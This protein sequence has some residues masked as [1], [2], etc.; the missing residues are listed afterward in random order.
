MALLVR[1]FFWG[2]FTGIVLLGQ[3]SVVSAGDRIESR[4]LY[5]L[6]QR[7]AALHKAGDRRGALSLAKVLV[8]KTEQTYGRTH[9]Q[10]AMALSNLALAHELSNEPENAE[11]LYL[12]A[13]EVVE[14]SLGPNSRLLGSILNNMAAAVFA[15]CRLAEAERIYAR[16]YRVLLKFLQPSHPEVHAAENNLRK[17]RSLLR[18]D[19][20]HVSVSGSSH[21]QR[22]A[23]R[24]PKSRI[25]LPPTCAGS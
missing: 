15:Q 2:I 24:R 14:A 11:Q 9:P 21:D 4:E 3:T 20:S 7:V 1:A 13:A 17:I 22:F 10:F 18:T 16:A 6:S 19:L 12:Q 23:D 25:Q 5:T 8:Q